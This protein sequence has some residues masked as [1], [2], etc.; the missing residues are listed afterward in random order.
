MGGAGGAQDADLA[1]ALQDGDVGDI[2]QAGQ[3]DDKSGS[4]D[5]AGEEHYLVERIAEGVASLGTVIDHEI[6]ATGGLTHG[7]LER[8]SGSFALG[9]HPH[10]GVGGSGAVE[11]LGG[12]GGDGSAPSL[13]DAGGQ[14]GAAGRP[15]EGDRGAVGNVIDFA[16]DKG[17]VVE[18]FQALGGANNGG[19]GGGVDGGDVGPFGLAFTVWVRSRMGTRTVP[20]TPSMLLMVEVRAA[21]SV[22]G[23]TPKI[24]MSVG[25]AWF[26]MF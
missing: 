26:R 25:E 8:L 13:P 2:G 16:D 6:L 1:G 19:N 5:Q 23:V 12:G 7:T 22:C 24:V 18:V 15:G 11:A 17:V 14:G 4:H 9:A 3:R 20:C 10:H 21:L